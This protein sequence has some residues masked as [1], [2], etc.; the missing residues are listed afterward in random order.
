MTAAAW[1]RTGRASVRAMRPVIGP[2]A[3]FGLASRPVPR[4]HVR[5]LALIL[6][7]CALTA[8]ATVAAIASRAEHSAGVRT[9]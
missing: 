1:Q 5:A 7:V 4:E 9:P 8:A 6:V 3:L 2:G